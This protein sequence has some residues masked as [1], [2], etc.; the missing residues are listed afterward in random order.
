MR[1]GEKI[2]Q[3]LLERIIGA[4][5]MGEVWSAWDSA[6]GRRVAIKV[7]RGSLV[8]TPA[9][10]D[11]FVAEAQRQAKLDHPNIPRVHDYF[12]DGR[13]TCLV[14]QLI[15]GESVDAI[16]ERDGALPLE[17]A[18]S[19]AKDFLSALNYAHQRGI[20]HRDVK[21]SNIILDRHGQAYLI[22]F[23]IALAIGEARMTR[24]GAFVGTFEYTSPEQIRTPRNVDHRT[25]VYSSGC[26]VYEMLTGRPPFVAAEGNSTFDI[27]R[28]HVFEAPPPLRRRRPEIPEEL[29][30]V[31]LLALAK[32]VDERLPGCGE[33]RRLLGRAL[34]RRRSSRWRRPG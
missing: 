1:A 22:D 32:G 25:D 34:D 13:A 16:I 31:V 17:T 12:I 27:E 3:Y 7:M 33:F 21:P 30:H 10:R 26:V 28:A 29:E 20:I 14:L 18:V 19:I 9:F 4:G 5:G 8:E 23:G 6:L 2:R 24:T 15:D 11:R